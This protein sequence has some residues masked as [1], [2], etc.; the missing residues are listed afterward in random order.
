MI[1]HIMILMMIMMMIMIIVMI[2]KIT[3]LLLDFYNPGAESPTL[4]P[5]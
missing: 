2:T 5:S 3:L 1:I 4:P